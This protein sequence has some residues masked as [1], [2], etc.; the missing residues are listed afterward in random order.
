MKTTAGSVDKPVG[1]GWSSGSKPLLKKV[2]KG[3]GS[4]VVLSFDKS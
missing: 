1:Y 3:L 2:Y 4:K